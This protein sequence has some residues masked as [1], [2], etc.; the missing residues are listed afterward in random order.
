MFE[1]VYTME[2]LEKSIKEVLIDFPIEK[3]ILF[4]SYATGTADKHS[5]IDLVIDSKGKLRGIDFYEVMGILTEKLGKNVDLIEESQLIKGGKA[6]QEVLK[7]GV[8]IY[9]K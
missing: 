8:V 5:D 1:E 9:G 2:E 7:T 4:G 6:E 3:A